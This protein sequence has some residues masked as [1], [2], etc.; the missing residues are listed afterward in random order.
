MQWIALVRRR[1]EKLSKY[2]ESYLVKIPVDSLTFFFCG[3]FM[4]LGGDLQRRTHLWPGWGGWDL[5]HLQVGTVRAVLKDELGT[6]SSFI[7]QPSRLALWLVLS[8]AKF[9]NLCFFALHFCPGR[10]FQARPVYEDLP[11]GQEP[12]P[13][14]VAPPAPDWEKTATVAQLKLTAVLYLQNALP[15]YRA[16]SHNLYSTNDGGSKSGRAAQNQIEAAESSGSSHKL[17]T[18][19]CPSPAE[20]DLD[21]SGVNPNGS[22]SWSCQN[23]SW[24][25]VRMLTPGSAHGWTWLR[26]C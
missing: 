1:R 2:V 5:L 12:P 26:H 4:A 13:N 7:I 19:Y 10:P 6:E 22:L 23:V 17:A 8:F 18:C 16:F 9:A 20:S 3:C 11:I 21:R 24:L 15:H 25:M 14:C